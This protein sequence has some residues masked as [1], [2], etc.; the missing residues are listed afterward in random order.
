MALISQT[1][2]P[3]NHPNTD[4]GGKPAAGYNVGNGVWC[5]HVSATTM[6]APTEQ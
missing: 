1:V 4:L 3:P 2:T 6:S 5:S